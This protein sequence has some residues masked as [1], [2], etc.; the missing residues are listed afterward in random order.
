MEVATTVD[1]VR[2]P[3][4]SG[5]RFRETILGVDWAM[6]VDTVHAD[7]PSSIFPDMASFHHLFCAVAFFAKG[8]PGLLAVLL[9]SAFVVPA[10]AVVLDWSTATWTPGSTSQS[11]DID[12]SHAGNDVTIS[13]T[14][15]TGG[16]GVNP[17][18]RTTAITG[19]ANTGGTGAT[20]LQLGQDFGSGGSSSFTVTITFNYTQGV[21]TTFSLWDIDNDDSNNA[22]DHISSI[23]AT[24]V[25]GGTFTASSVSAGSAITQIGSGLSAEYTGNTST[26]DSPSSTLGVSFAT[27]P[28]TT[29]S[30]TYG[31]GA[32]ANAG[33]QW[34]ALSNI[35]FTPIPE[36]GASLGALSLCLGILLISRIR[37]RVPMPCA[38]G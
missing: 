23:M 36:T 11:F 15:N 2:A 33:Q 38:Q 4:V 5:R 9:W 1:G 35:S 13:I 28:A 12:P 30:F 21:N 26:V 16:F 34:I 27:T 24:A 14:G 31:K 25:G 10:R 29:I 22:V 32:S 6:A 8:L 18:I 7:G 19:Q 37:Q 3:R 17:A 20:S